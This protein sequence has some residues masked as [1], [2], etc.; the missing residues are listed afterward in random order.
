MFWIR[1]GRLAKTK[2]ANQAAKPTAFAKSEPR[3]SEYSSISVQSSLGMGTGHYGWSV[4][5][6][7]SRLAL[8]EPHDAAIGL[9]PIT[10][11]TVLLS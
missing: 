1:F 7:A 3:R 10:S 5:V 2:C 4:A 11:V 9:D 6:F 8:G